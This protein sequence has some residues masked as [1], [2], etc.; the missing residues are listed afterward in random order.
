VY[1]VGLF[2]A[3][4]SWIMRKQIDRIDKLEGDREMH[5]R[6]SA[7]ETNSVTQE[8]LHYTVDQLRD[9]IKAMETTLS[10]GQSELRQGHAQIM[11]TLLNWRKD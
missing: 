5:E 2:T 9:D 6:V 11:Q 4:M 10:G 3:V 8:T 1:V 7:L